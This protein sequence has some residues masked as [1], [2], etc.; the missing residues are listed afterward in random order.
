[1]PETMSIERRRVLAAFGADRA[2]SRQCPA[3]LGNDFV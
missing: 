3:A 2:H 1:M